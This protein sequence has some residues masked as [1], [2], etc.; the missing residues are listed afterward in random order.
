MRR[1]TRIWILAIGCLLVAVGALA[2]TKA[3]QI[4]TMVRAGEAQV[5]PP[6]T[7]SAARVDPIAWRASRAA[8]GSLVAV[9]GVTLTAELP[10]RVREIGFDSGS[11]VK[12]GALLVRLDTSSEA[13]QLAAA[14]AE[15]S[16]ASISLRRARELRGSG[17]NTQADLDAAVAQA[18]QTAAAASNLRATIA[19]KT[20]RAPFDGRISIRKVELGQV[21]APGDPIATL[22][23]LSPIYAEF[24]LQQQALADL[25]TG[26]AAVLR[27]DTFPNRQW[28]GEVTIINPAV[29][30]ATRS[31]RVR[32]TFDN[33]G[34]DLRPG[35]FV[36]VEVLARD[37]RSV[38]AVPATAIIYAPYGD[39]VFVIPQ[40]AQAASGTR[41]AQ[42]RFIQ[43]GE[44]RGDFVEVLSGLTEGETVA[45]SGAFKLRNGAAV[46]V[47][48]ALAPDAGLT[49][50]PIDR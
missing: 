17:A 7:V 44:R 6:E 19:K 9:R 30:E 5:I 25:H 2:G 32:A 18:A 47:N 48:N 37:Q 41:A 29:E 20:I 10:G 23:S 40:E 14:T 34:G 16:L 31:V 38:L 12:K 50:K 36:N 35:M 39:S 3:G 22:S 1:R 42:Q 45:T 49:P 8:I 24:S 43:A 15:S 28:S 27:T 4:V 13:A 11:D 26:Q 21:L 33:P 46:V